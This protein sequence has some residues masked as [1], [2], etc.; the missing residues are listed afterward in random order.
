M[1]SRQFI[2]ILHNN[3]LR[4]SPYAL[5][6]PSSNALFVRNPRVTYTFADETEG[7]VKETC[8]S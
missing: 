1:K 3:S 8:S 5:Y 6:L 4:E 2:Y 7:Y